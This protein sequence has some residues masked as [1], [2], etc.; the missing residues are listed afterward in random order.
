[1][2][3]W[4]QSIVRGASQGGAGGTLQKRRGKRVG[5]LWCVGRDLPFAFFCL[6]ARL[7]HGCPGG[8]LEGDGVGRGGRVV[9]RDTQSRFGGRS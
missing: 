1:M 3:F 9:L 4:P 7:C 8:V 2:S 6:D 5:V